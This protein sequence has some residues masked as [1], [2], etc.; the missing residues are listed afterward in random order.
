MRA[1]RAYAAAMPALDHGTRRTARRALLAA[2]CAAAACACASTAA[3]HSSVERV[4]PAGGAVLRSA[5]A[6]VRVTYGAPLASVTSASARVGSR[7]LAGAPRIDPADARRL[8]IP[9][10]E[11]VPGA[12]RVSWVVAGTDGH[13]LSG[14]TGFRVRVPAEVTALHR[15]AATV[16]A[17]ARALRAAADAAATAT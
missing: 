8:V 9:L 16:A 3:G 17:A 14:R 5:P 6:Q 11:G 7:D 12:Y 10:R 15:V 13:A 1:G 2:A 4:Q